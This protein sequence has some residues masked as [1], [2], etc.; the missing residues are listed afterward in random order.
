MNLN[1]LKKT[2]SLFMAV[3]IIGSLAACSGGTTTVTESEVIISADNGGN[4]EGDTNETVSDSDKDAS[5]ADKGASNADKGSTSADKGSSNKNNTSSGDKKPSNNNSGEYNPYEGIEKYK[6][7]TIKLALWWKPTTNEQKVIDDF[8]SKYGMTVK[9]ET[10]PSV[11]TYIT[12]I[13][14]QISSGQ[15]PDLCAIKGEDYLTFIQTNLVQPI[16]VG[17]FD[18][19]KDKKLDLATMNK[20]SWKGKIYGINLANNM[21]YSR[22]CI[23]YNKTMFENAGLKTPYKLWK[24]N[25]WNWDIFA[26]YAKKLTTR[27]GNKIIYGYTGLDTTIEGWL[28]SN[29]CDFITSDGN[30]LINN[31]TSTKVQETLTFISELREN[32]YWCPD[33][34]TFTFSN[35]EAAMMGEGSWIMEA[36]C[37]PKNVDWEVVPMPSPKGAK[38]VIPYSCTLWSIATGSKEPIAASY[39]I[40]YWLDF[41]NF[42]LKKAIPNEQ[43]REVFEYM[44]DTSKNRQTGMSRSVAGYYDGAQYWSLLNVSRKSANDIPVDLKKVATVMDGIIK[45]IEAK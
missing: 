3:A 14:S 33:E 25:K 22:Y 1:F 30:K 44:S 17:K 40:R 26:E 34:S 24:E 23:Y 28:L 9:V 41:D 8:K 37:V 5:S 13:T 29:G 20:L 32:G 35:G 10:T 27:K 15:G 19:E 38:E 12:K 6:G 45:K 36:S 31:V 2:V 21:T 11:A 4:A 43:A 18:L 42:N 16:T 7:K 39:F